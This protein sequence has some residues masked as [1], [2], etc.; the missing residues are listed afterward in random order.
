MPDL[1]LLGLS[2]HAQINFLHEVRAE[3]PSILIWGSSNDSHPEPSKSEFKA[4][5][6]GPAEIDLL[7]EGLFGAEGSRLIL[8]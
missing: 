5:G 7:R 6:I 2:K 3:Y 1:L 8:I 4:I